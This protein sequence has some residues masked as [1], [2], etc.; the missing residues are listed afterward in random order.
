MSITTLSEAKAH[1][2]IGTSDE[3]TL[4]QIY[5][6]AAEK[7][8]SNQLNRALYAT[9]AGTDTTGLVM[10]EAVKVA[11]LL[12]VGHWYENRESVTTVQG[13]N[14]KELPLAFTWLLDQ[15][16]YGMGV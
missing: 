7:A 12:L 3:D 9:T 5:L 11:V 4:L 13:A 1:L 8:A 16:R 10:T 2:R 15:E 14:I 6:N